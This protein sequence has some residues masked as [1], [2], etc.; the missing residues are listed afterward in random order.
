MVHQTRQ[1]ILDNARFSFLISERL[2]LPVEEDAARDTGVTLLHMTPQAFVTAYD[3]WQSNHREW[4]EE[5]FAGNLVRSAGVI[6]T[7]HDLQLGLVEELT[8]TAKL[9]DDDESDS[10]DLGV[11]MGEN[12]AREIASFPELSGEALTSADLATFIV[13]ITVEHPQTEIQR[14]NE[15]QFFLIHDDPEDPEFVEKAVAIRDQAA[16]ESLDREYHTEFDEEPYPGHDD[17]RNRQ[18]AALIEL[19]GGREAYQTFIRQAAAYDLL[20]GGKIEEILTDPN[21]LM[22]ARQLQ[23]EAQIYGFTLREPESIQHN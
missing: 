2:P 3:V 7:A 8:E 16:D 15:R 23:T 13:Q 11:L 17:D 12:L 19:L 1:E 4:K 9:T 20:A 22:G 14:E 21:T 5:P 18:E 10:G 6:A